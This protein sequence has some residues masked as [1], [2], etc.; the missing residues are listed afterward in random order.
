MARKAP[1]SVELRLS[2]HEAMLMQ[3][4]LGV[5]RE[6]GGDALPAGSRKFLDDQLGRIQLQMDML[7]FRN[8]K[9]APYP[10]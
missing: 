9:K 5:V 10:I 4:L 2:V 3:Q 1:P 8:L 7:Y 6:L